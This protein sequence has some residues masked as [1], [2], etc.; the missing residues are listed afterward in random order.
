MGRER[1]GREGLRVE[2]PVLF[3]CP[4]SL[5]LMKSPVSLCTGITYDRSSI[6]PWIEAGHSTCPATMQVLPSTELIPNLTL[7]RLIHIWSSSQPSSSK[8]VPDSSCY[9]KLP[10]DSSSSSSKLVPDSSCYSKFPPDSSSSSS[11]L[12][13]DSS[14]YSKFL[15]DSSSSSCKSVP[16]SSCY[17]KPLQDSSSSSSKLVLDSSCSSKLLLNSSSSSSKLVLDSSCYS[18][19]LLESLSLSSSSTSSSSSSS[20]LAVLRTGGEPRIP[21]RPVDSGDVF[22]LVGMLKGENLAAREAA[23]GIIEATVDPA[24]I[25]KEDSLL[26]ELAR[27]AWEQDNESAA[28]GLSCLAALCASRKAREKIFAG[29][30]VA[31]AVKHLTG[32]GG[33]AAEKAAAF[34]AAAARCSE[35]RAAIGGDAAAAMVGSMMRLSSAAREAAVAA[36]WLVC[37]R[38]RD[39]R[40]GLAAARGG[41][42]TKML[43]IMQ[44]D[45]SPATK[46]M[47]RDL[48]KLFRACGAAS[49]AKT[50]D[51]APF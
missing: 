15:L 42:L 13:P 20:L 31:A 35:G 34:M 7:R 18:E 1:R 38:F 27:L 21:R 36:L 41:G 49:V 32:N 30:A 28:A 2:V 22:S 23:A 33:A 46:E 10:P 50:A 48:I 16:D 51:I 43:L 47:A 4:I 44:S 3:R 12:V 40:A 9:S 19:L 14:C 45:C 24:I 5:E 39:R 6:K 8:L 37:C 29:G 17:S 11:K 25:A 26:A